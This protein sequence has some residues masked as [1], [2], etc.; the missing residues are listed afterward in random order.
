MVRSA[1]LFDQTTGNAITSLKEWYKDNSSSIP[2]QHTVGPLRVSQLDSGNI[3]ASAIALLGCGARGDTVAGA[4]DGALNGSI[5]A[6]FNIP[7]GAP[8]CEA[9]NDGPSIVNDDGDKVVTA[10]NADDPNAGAVT[11]AVLELYSPLT[12]GDLGTAVQYR[13]DTRDMF[14]YHSKN[15]NVLHADGS[16]RSYSDE[17]GDGFINPGFGIDPAELRHSH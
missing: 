14:A 1:P 3:P 10:N 13:Q 5:P 7:A 8:A 17:N 15:L 6:P 4:G 11:R 12:K 2:V 16:V 9:F